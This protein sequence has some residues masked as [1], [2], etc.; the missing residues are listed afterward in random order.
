MWA[1]GTPELN[2]AVVLICGLFLVPF[3]PWIGWEG[4]GTV[5]IQGDNNRF[6]EYLASAEWMT[7]F[8]RNIRVLRVWVFHF[9][10]HFHLDEKLCGAIF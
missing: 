1:L 3:V 5:I 9:R 6:G 7:Q 10:N 4:I 8:R 2:T